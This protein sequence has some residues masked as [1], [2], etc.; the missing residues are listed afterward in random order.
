MNRFRQIVVN[1]LSN[2]V[3]FTDRGE[4]HLTGK[5]R[6]IEKGTEKEKET[7]MFSP[8]SPLDNEE[9][10]EVLVSVADTGVGIAESARKIIFEPFTQGTSKKHR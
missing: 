6:P 2:A 1:L 4:V 3:K 5:M 7:K 8:F 10:F 9:L